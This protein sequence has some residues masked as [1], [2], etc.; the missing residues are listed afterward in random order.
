M[1]AVGASFEYCM[2][3][4]YVCVT[5]LVKTTSCVEFVMMPCNHAC[6]P[7]VYMFY[8]LLLLFAVVHKYIG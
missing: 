1:E 6:I 7:P 4:E 8:S 2:D 3:E 5:V